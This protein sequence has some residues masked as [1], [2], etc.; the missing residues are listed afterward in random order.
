MAP[1]VIYRWIFVYSIIYALRKLKFGERVVIIWIGE[2][3]LKMMR[4]GVQSIFRIHNP[5]SLG[6]PHIQNRFWK[7]ISLLFILCFEVNNELGKLLNPIYSREKDCFYDIG[8]KVDTSIWESQPRLQNNFP[9]VYF[10]TSNRFRN[11][12]SCYRFRT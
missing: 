7:I 8:Q 11:L 2:T 10:L 9:W 3:Q 12:I 5:S 4:E 6:Y 1:D